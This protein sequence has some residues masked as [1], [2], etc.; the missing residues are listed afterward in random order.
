MAELQEE[1]RGRGEE[2]GFHARLLHAELGQ[3]FSRAGS[4]IAQPKETKR[5]HAGHFKISNRL[6]QVSFLF[7]VTTVCKE[8]HYLGTF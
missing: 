1:R 8:C 2:T 5:S 4:V 6:N 3:C 7:E